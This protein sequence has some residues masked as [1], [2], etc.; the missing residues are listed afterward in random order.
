MT[1]SLPHLWVFG[2]MAA[3][4]GLVLVLVHLVMRDGRLLL[5]SSIGGAL[6]CLA[7]LGILLSIG[8]SFFGIYSVL[9]W[10]IAFFAGYAASTPIGYAIQYLLLKR[11]QTVS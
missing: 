8:K 10:I 9:A 2:H 4:V 5:V 6:G 11:T 7:L 1:I 3:M